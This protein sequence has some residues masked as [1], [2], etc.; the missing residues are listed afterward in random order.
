MKGGDESLIMLLVLWLLSRRSIKEVKDDGET[1]VVIII[2]LLFIFSIWLG[3]K[4]DPGR[5]EHI[6]N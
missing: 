6:F 5:T 1:F 4:L 2:V 3:I